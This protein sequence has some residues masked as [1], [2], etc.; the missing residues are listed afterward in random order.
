MH[1]GEDL[2][3]LGVAIV[4]AQVLHRFRI[5]PVKMLCVMLTKNDC[6]GLCR[7]LCRLDLKAE[8]LVDLL[9]GHALV[10]CPMGVRPLAV[11]GFIDRGH[12]EEG[13]L[14]QRSRC[15]RSAQQPRQDSSRERGQEVDDRPDEVLRSQ[16]RLRLPGVLCDCA[17]IWIRCI[18]VHS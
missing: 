7:V 13:P 2:V 8:D 5:D 18:K 1:E 3:H 17:I 14:S 16:R 9:Q 6:R 12:A 11:A 15:L 10:H 4:L